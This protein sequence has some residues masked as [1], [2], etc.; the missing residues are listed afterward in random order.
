M[1][2]RGWNQSCA[3]AYSGQ[4]FGWTQDANFDFKSLGRHT[5]FGYEVELQSV[6]SNSFPSEKNQRWKLT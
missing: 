5:D 3:T 4:N 2:S 1:V 6:F